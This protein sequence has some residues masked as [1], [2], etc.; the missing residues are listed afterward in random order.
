MRH[1]REFWVYWT[2][3]AVLNALATL[4]WFGPWD[5]SW[6]RSWWTVAIAA[7]LAVPLNVGGFVYLGMLSQDMQKLRSD[8]WLIPLLGLP[9]VNWLSYSVFFAF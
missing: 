4:P 9:G 3:V 8:G 1:L 6:M 5:L 7:V 2:A